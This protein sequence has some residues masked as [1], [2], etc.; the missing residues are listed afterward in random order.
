MAEFE[1]NVI[2]ERTNAG[3][4]AAARGRKGGRPAAVTADKLKRARTLIDQ[5]LTVREAAGRVKV[6]KT[7]L[8]KALA[9]VAGTTTAGTKPI[10]KT[11]GPT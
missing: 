2:R 1:R 6:G 5:G 10:E 11:S 3:L 9:A 7:A 8:Y 4:T